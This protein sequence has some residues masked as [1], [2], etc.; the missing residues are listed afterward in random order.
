MSPRDW[1]F[2]IQ[3]IVDALTHI[4][5]YIRGMSYEQWLNDRKTVDA[6]IRNLEIIG[7]AAKH[8]PPETMNRYSDIPWGKMR[9]MRNVLIHEYFGVDVEI[10]WKTV[11]EDLPILK[12]QLDEVA[13]GE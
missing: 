11:T 4:E 6:V 1:L 9:A 10:I 7:E 3:D 13:W 2:R 5:S 12:R 8:I